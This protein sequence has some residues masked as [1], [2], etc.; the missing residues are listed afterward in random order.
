MPRLPDHELLR[1]HQRDT[2]AARNGHERGWAPLSG[3]QGAFELE[4]AAGRYT[5]EAE[6][7]GARASTTIELTPGQHLD[8]VALLLATQTQVSGRL[9]DERGV[10]RAG[11]IVAVL[12]AAGP[13][14]V[15]KLLAHAVTDAR[16]VFMIEGLPDNAREVYVLAGT[17]ST[18]EAFAAA[19]ELR[20]FE[21]APGSM[22]SLADVVMAEPGE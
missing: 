9:V 15:D 2:G 22:T 13:R 5:L 3:T 18:P 10:P 14:A 6:A 19:A 1:R 17:E 21:L 11:W 12:D 8:G 4:L 20:R 7:D 16:G